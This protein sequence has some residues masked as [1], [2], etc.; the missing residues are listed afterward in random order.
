MNKNILYAILAGTAAFGL[1]SCDENS[2]NDHF[3]DG[4]EGGVDYDQSQTGSYTLTADDY[5]AISKLMTSEATTDAEKTAAKAIASKL[6]FNKESE[7]PGSYAIIPFLSTSTFPYFLAGNGST[8]DIVF[9]EAVNAPEELTAIA[10]ATAYTVSADN[11]KEMWGSDEDYIEGFAPIYSAAKNLPGI[12]KAN[13]ADAVSG[14]YAVVSYKEAS[15]NPVFTVSDNTPEVFLDAT[16]AEGDEGFTM[17]NVKLPEGS[18]YVWKHD[19]YKGDSYMKA[20]GYVNKASRE[21]E[22]WII[23]PEVELK[24][25]STLTFDQ[26]WRNFKSVDNA[27]AEATVWVRVKGGSWTEV[28]P[29]NFPE[30]TS[31]DFYPSGDIDLSAYTGKTIQLGFCYKSSTAS[32]GTWEVKNVLIQESVAARGGRALAAEVATVAKNAV[33]YFNGSAWSVATGVLALNPADYT[34][35]GFNNNALSDPDIYIPLYLKNALPYALSGAQE[36]VVYNKNNADLFVYDGTKWTLNNVG[37]ETV[38]GRFEK[39]NGEWSFVKYIGKAIYTEF[40]EQTI[41]LDRSYLIVAGGACALPAAKSSN[42]GYINVTSVSIEGSQ[43]IMP[44]DVNGFLFASSY[45]DGNGG[46]FKAPEGQ[47]LIA[48]S[49]KRYLYMSGTYNSFNFKNAPAITD[50]AIDPTYLWTAAP[51]GDGTWTLKNV[52]SSQTRIWGYSTNHT[53]YGAYDAITGVAGREFPALYIL[54]E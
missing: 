2:W 30:N 12:L 53:S 10:G 54:S 18:T 8:V 50:K 6:Y 51:N 48:D 19:S 13:I 41:E 17:D 21:S 31:Y 34:A 25:N 40:N 22:G 15:V 7:Y 24:A 52:G 39:K 14:N 42:F 49:N 37:L 32:A 46:V 43:I 20:S 47:F 33:Y 28:K 44:T 26:A 3:L 5:A 9:N 4:F 16:F 38:T 11:Y 35:M 36:Y 1:A 29:L 27:K 23:S 45:D